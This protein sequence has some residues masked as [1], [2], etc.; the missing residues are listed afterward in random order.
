MIIA[1][2]SALL[3]IVS[4]LLGSPFWYVPSLVGTVAIVGALIER[5]TII[6]VGMFA[7]IYIFYLTNHMLPVTILSIALGLGM[8]FLFFVSWDLTRRAYLVE[9]IE[10]TGSSSKTPGFLRGFKKKSNEELILTVIIG[11]SV[12]FIG[13]YIAFYGSIGLE[14]TKMLVVPAMVLFG[15]VVL[16]VLYGLV[17]LVPKMR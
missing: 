6:T 7:S 3:A 4:G 2:Y 12:S 17:I 13:A 15:A 11:F 5:K 8:F 14:V 16:I 10:K 9:L 1:S